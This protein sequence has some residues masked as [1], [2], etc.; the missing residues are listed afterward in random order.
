[1][2]RLLNSETR[3]SPSVRLQYSL[4]VGAIISIPQLLQSSMMH[5][6]SWSA[7]QVAIVA[8]GISEPKS[9]SK[10][11]PQQKQKPQ[12]APQFKQQ[13]AKDPPRNAQPQGSQPG[14]TQQPQH[15]PRPH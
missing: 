15:Y 8:Q 11:T 2:R 3:K 12:T 7:S 14:H 4:L 6:F 10:G 13:P 1:M 9:G 5:D